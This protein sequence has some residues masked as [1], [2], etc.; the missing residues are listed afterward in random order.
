MLITIQNKVLSLTVDTLGAQMM[1]LKST[2]GCQYLWQGDPQYWGDRAPV[3][4]PFIARLY[5]DAYRL[6]GKR[7]EM[8]IHGFAA[9]SEFAVAEQG[10]D[11]LTLRLENT[12][13]TYGVYPCA[14]ALDITYRM[15]DNT[16]EVIYSVS[17]R[18]AQTMHFGIG[19]HPGFCVPL[20]A[21]EQFADYRLIFGEC[22]VPDRIGFTDDL[23]LSGENKQ[24]TL[25]D[26][27]EIPLSHDLFDEDA[28]ILQN[29]AKK[30]TLCSKGKR[31]V[32]VAYPDMP[33]LGIWHW[34]K[35]DAPYVCIEPWTSLP[36]RQ[37]VEEEFS[38]KSDLIHLSAGETYENIWTITVT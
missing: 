2:D 34:P 18:D 20:E 28:V 17:N 5:R 36:A 22:C 38:C 1:S 15:V 33:Y 3:L 29:M 9:A 19:G 6:N 30:V 10:E 13:D 16:V 7:Y 21:G 11:H 4:F 12:Q 25:K 31:S 32:T 26:G 14:F 24:Y 37:D 23:L 8:K 27:N 35:T